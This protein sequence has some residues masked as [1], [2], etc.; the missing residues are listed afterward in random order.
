MTAFPS[1][2]SEN[3][4]PLAYSLSDV[5]RIAS[6]SRPT[7]FRAIRAGNLRAV[8]FGRRTLILEQDLRKF[9]AALPAVR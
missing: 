2:S 5:P 6:L 4:V 9:L 8:K 1:R 7:I 3:E